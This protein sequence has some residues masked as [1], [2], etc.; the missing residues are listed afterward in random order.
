MS[1]IFLPEKKSIKKWSETPLKELNWEIIGKLRE[2][3]LSMLNK[4]LLNLNVFQDKN[5]YLDNNFSKKIEESIFN[6]SEDKNQTTIQY[7][8]KIAIS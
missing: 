4:E 5:L 1:K 7:I 8:N 3:L 2:K 6:S